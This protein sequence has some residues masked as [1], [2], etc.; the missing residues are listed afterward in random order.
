MYVISEKH[1]Q[2]AQR[3][4]KGKTEMKIVTF[5]IERKKGEKNIWVVYKLRHIIKGR[6][7]LQQ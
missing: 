6:F 3:V 7:K 5:N 1:L 2:F 4:E